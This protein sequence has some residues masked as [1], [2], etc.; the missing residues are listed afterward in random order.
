MSEQGVSSA[1]SGDGGGD[2]ADRCA[3]A[4]VV[5]HNV[6]VCVGVLCVFYFILVVWLFFWVSRLNIFLLYIVLLCIY[7]SGSACMLVC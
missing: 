6:C 5:S 1:R 4:D 2:G 7:F 3:R